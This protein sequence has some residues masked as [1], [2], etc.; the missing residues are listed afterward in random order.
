MAC[1]QGKS[2]VCKCTARHVFAGNVIRGEGSSH[3]GSSD[4]QNSTDPSHRFPG[5]VAGSEESYAR[6]F[7]HYGRDSAIW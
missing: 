1:G 7:G 2:W 3:E 6:K 5:A 4:G